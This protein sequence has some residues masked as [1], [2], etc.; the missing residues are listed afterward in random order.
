M[1]ELFL[2]TENFCKNKNDFDE[3]NEKYPPSDALYWK[4]FNKRPMFIV[5]GQ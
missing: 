4:A 1:K 3:K 5:I 2:E